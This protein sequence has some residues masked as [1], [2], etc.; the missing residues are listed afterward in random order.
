ML[1]TYQDKTPD[2]AKAAFV[3]ENATLVGDVTLSPGSSIWYGAVLRGDLD[4]IIIGENSNV[5]DNVTLHSDTGYPVVLGR[6]VTVG[7]NAVVHGATVGDDTLIGMG[8]VVLDDAVIG[9]ECIVGA[10]AL[11]T[12]GAHFPDGSLILGSPAKAVSELHPLQIAK[13]RENAEDYCKLAA[14]YAAKEAK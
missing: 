2:I 9:K 6:G 13:N 4:A 5:Q 7:H 11:V 10:G 14:E 3:A 1:V 12:A 8:A